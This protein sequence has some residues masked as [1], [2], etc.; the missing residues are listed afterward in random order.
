MGAVPVE[1]PCRVHEVLVSPKGDVSLCY[2]VQRYEL[3]DGLGF[4]Q[5][6]AHHFWDNRFILVPRSD[7]ERFLA[8]EGKGAMPEVGG[9]ELRK[10]LVPSLS[11]PPD[12]SRV[13]FSQVPDPDRGIPALPARDVLLSSACQ[14]RLIALT[15]VFAYP[16]PRRDD[17]AGDRRRAE[18]V[19]VRFHLPKGPTAKPSS[20]IVRALLTPPAAIADATVD[21]VLIVTAPVWYPIGC[22]P[23]QGMGEIPVGHASGGAP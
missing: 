7:M 2:L 19:T 20:T 22:Q 14:A 10:F 13:A 12:A 18:E 3:V 9:E 21:A 11:R 4:G 17:R 1:E 6:S 5:P 8:R 15:V 16:R 23:W